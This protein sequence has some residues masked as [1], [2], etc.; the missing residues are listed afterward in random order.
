MKKM[1][2]YVALLLLVCL[3]MSQ[4][5]GATSLPKLALT[6]PEDTPVGELFTVEVD[7]TGNPGMA[8]V[9][10]TLGF[11]QTVLDCTSADVG[12]LMAGMLYATNPD[13]TDGAIIAG[14]STSNVDGDGILGTLTFTVL[15][16]GSYEFTL[17]EV[18]VAGIDGVACD[19]ETDL[20]AQGAVEEAETATEEVEPTTGST[21]SGSTSSVTATEEEESTFTDTAG[22]WAEEAI[23]EAAALE[24]VNGYGNGLFGPD[25]TITR[26]QLVTILW[27]NAGS[28]EPTQESSFIDLT[29]DYYMD[30]VAWG[31]ENG[32]LNGYGG[33]LFGPD[34]AVTREQV[35][36]ILFRL[37]GSDLGM[38]QLY[39]AIYDDAFSDEETVTT[40][41]VEGIYWA[42]YYDIWCGTDSFSVGTDLAPTQGA[43]RG[44]I[45]VMLT[46]YHEFEGGI[47]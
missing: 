40:G 3:L 36:A 35:A 38:S 47:E 19:V 28:T 18:V 9:Q 16:E 21:S 37:N 45:A 32:V 29:D 41:M 30:A 14:A 2:F 24:L 20:G 34:D 8:A 4:T 31:E 13:A 17:S 33:G 26:G 7:L 43:T 1:R 25:D 11:D 39:T 6:Y 22:H 10:F 46:A 5:V 42:I 12:E 27:R 15:S 23:E 44:Q